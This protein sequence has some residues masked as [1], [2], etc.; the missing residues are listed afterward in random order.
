MG[1]GTCQSDIISGPSWGCQLIMKHFQWICKDIGFF[2]CYDISL[3][4][5]M[6]VPM[7]EIQCTFMNI[8]VDVHIN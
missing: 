4:I 5:C 2:M 7:Y 1:E 8:H 3:L 6:C